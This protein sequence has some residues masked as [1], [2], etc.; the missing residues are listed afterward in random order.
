MGSHATAEIRW[1]NELQPAEI[2][3]WPCVGSYTLSHKGHPL[4]YYNNFYCLLIF[5]FLAHYIL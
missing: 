4:C 1:P 2:Q 3:R 5:K